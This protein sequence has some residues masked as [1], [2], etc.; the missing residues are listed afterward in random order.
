VILRTQEITLDK[1][2]AAIIDL[3]EQK[4]DIGFLERLKNLFKKMLAVFM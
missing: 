2:D 3:E 4:T 1:G